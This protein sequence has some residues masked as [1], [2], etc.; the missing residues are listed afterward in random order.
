MKKIFFKLT[1]LLF[2]LGMSVNA[3]WATN[4]SGM[5]D[6]DALTQAFWARMTA[7]PA[8]TTLGSGLVFVSEDEH[9]VVPADE[10]YASTYSAEGWSDIYLDASLAILSATV[11]FKVYAKANA[12][13]YFTGWSFTDG[14]T[15]L[16]VGSGTYAAIK[17]KPSRKKSKANILD[18]TVYAAFEQVKL[19]SYEVS[20]DNTMDPSNPTCTQTVTFRAETPGFSALNSADDAKHFKLPVITN[21]AGTAGTWAT[22]ITEWNTSNISFYGDYAEIRVPVTF[23]APNGNE[24]EYGAEL[25]LETQAG[26]SMKVYLSA[27]TTGGEGQAVRYDKNGNEMGRGNLTDMIAASAATDVVKLN[28]DYA[29][30]VEINKNLTFNLNG[31]T[32]SNTLTVSGGNV[33][34]AYSAF[35]GTAD[36]LNVTGGKAIL[37]GGTFGTLTIGANATV[38]QNGA[39]ITGAATNNGT[40]T[41]TDGVFQ[42]GLTSTK[43]LTVNGGTFNGAT[44]INVTGGT[45][46]IKRGTISGTQY[47]VLTTNG[48]SATIEKLAVI[49][50]GTKALNNV[51]GTLTVNNGK[52]ADPSKFANGEITFKSAYFKTDAAAIASTYEKQQWRNTAGPEFRDEYLYFVGDQDAAQ[53]SNVSVC[54]IGKTSYASLDDAL[55]YANNHLSEE[56]II[57]MENDYTLKAGYYTIPA[58]ATLIVPMSDDQETANPV[59]PRSTSGTSTPVSFRKLIFESGVNMEVAGTLEVTCTQYGAGESMGIPG[60]NYGHLILKPG[61]HMTINNGGYLRAWGFVT[62]DGTQDSDGNYLSGE[63]DVRRGG[64]VHEMFQMGDWKGGDISFT[65]A[66]EIPGMNPCWRDM[67]HLFPIYTY[68]I[69]NVESPVKYHPGASL[70]CATSV[71]V[72]GEI[73]A[74]ANDIKVVGKEGEAAMFLMDEMADAENTWVRKYYDAKKDQ[75]VYEVNSGAKLG[76]VV[77]DLGEVPAGLITS[78]KVTGTLNLVLDSR[79]FV[80]PLTNNFKIHLLSGY[81]EFTQST[82]CLPGME[83]EVDKESEVAITKNDDATIVSGALY[84]YDADQW[85]FQNNQ[86]FGYV[87]DGKFGAIVRY[88]PTWDLGTNGATKKPEVRDISS[89]AAI[90][91]AKLIVHGTFRS[92]EDCSVYTSWSKDMT[93]LGLDESGTGGASII[94]TNEDAGT[95]IFDADAPAFDGLEM[96]PSTGMPSHLGTSVLVNYDHNDYDMDPQYPITINT[97]LGSSARVYGF[98][99]CTPAKLKN[100]DGTF[101]E[102]DG[103]LAGTSYCYIDDQWTTMQVAEDPCFMKE[104][105]GGQ[106]TYYAKPAEYVAVNVTSRVDLG[107]GVYVFNGNADHTFSDKDGAGRLFILMSDCQWWEVE[108]KDNLYHCIHPDN[109][110]YYY[111]DET[112]SAWKE[113]RFTITWLNWNGTEIKSYT[114]DVSSGDTVWE[115]YSVTYGTQAEYLGSNPTR[116]PNIDYTYDFTGWAPAL[117]KV[118][119]DVTYTATYTEQPRKYAIIFTNEGGDEIE[120]HLLT[121]NEIPVCENV[122][123]R[124]GHTLQW[125]PALAA[126][127]GDQTYRATWLEEPPTEY[128]IRFVDYDGTTVLKSDTVA[129]GEMP[130]APIITDGKPSGSEEGKPKTKEFTYVF[131]HWSP[132]VEEVTQAMTY[133]AVYREV[134]R[135]YTVTFKNEDNTTLET[136]TY[137]YGETPACSKLQT[138]ANTAQYTIALRWTPQIQ[139]VMEDTTYTAV[140]DT[141]TNK[142]TVSAKCSPAGAATFT[143][144]GTFDYGTIVNN[145]ALSYDSEAYE[146]LGWA[147]LTGAAKTVTTHTAFTLTKDTTIVADFRYKGDDKVTITWKNWDGSDTIGTSEPKVNAATTYTGAT[148][149]KPATSAE[150]YTFDGWTTEAKGKGTYYKNNLTP[151]ATANATYYAHFS[152]A[153]IPSLEVSNGV[154]QLSAP[155]TYQNLIL[156]SDGVHS[157]Q[158]LGQNYLTLTGNAYFDFK[159]NTQPRK[160]YAI[161]VPWLVD[162]ATGISANGHALTLNSGVY[163]LTYDGARRA[164]QGPQKTW[165]QLSN[166]DVMQPGILYMVCVMENASSIRFA[167][168][169]GADLLTTT[170]SVSEYPEATDNDNKDASWNGVANPAL[171]HAYVNAGVTYGQVYIPE[172]DS[173]DPIVLNTTKLVV[174]QGAYVQVPADKNITV[175]QGGEFGPTSAPRRMVAENETSN[176]EV[177]FAPI[178]QN[179]ED[180]VFVQTDDSKTPD[181]YT[182]GLDLAKMGVS[183]KIAQIW[184]DRYD[185]KLCLNTMAPVNGEAD[186]PLVLSVP[187]DG[188][189]TIDI[190]RSTNEQPNE[191]YLTR[192]GEAIWNLSQNAYTMRLE[193]GTTARYG[194]RTVSKAPQVT[195]DFEPIWVDP[196]GNAIKAAKVLINNHVY[197]I[198]DGKLYTITGSLVR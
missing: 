36:E 16:G 186:Y 125:E 67:A 26:V 21:K 42:S 49:S 116:E 146:F 118:T 144:A 18:Y 69:Q 4:M 191:L 40:L 93:T 11:D 103:T 9:S 136:K 164:A 167:K 132:A 92:G 124:T 28:G 68:F 113:Q 61:S 126:V 194:L 123:T 5:T 39:T 110:T 169:A 181:V 184:I 88:S 76:S 145:V 96:D 131:D 180:R 143:G 187:Q 27:R 1:M 190:L 79:K 24:A 130:V 134:Q 34:I 171:F 51:N 162:A 13:S 58:N 55:S 50:G 62:G 84:F 176:Y 196:E 157:G 129:V 38:E 64:T 98:E 152:A 17:V 59:V 155:V 2:L 82:S 48:G 158:L 87:G 178:N 91:D 8:T 107:E 89:P 135:E 30:P 3:A 117:G 153:S 73:N 71:N 195:T 121:H 111:W 10:D 174:G 173:Y 31:Y 137:H 179:F 189:Y 90:G 105:V 66:M 70:I 192:D 22:S 159:V 127:V 100:A 160:W 102:T 141:T 177:R 139:T 14:Y 163:V 94:S 122:P 142:Y 175:T 32:L 183:A 83:V 54:R 75:Q 133:T 193:Q 119:S 109:D 72:A 101:V 168:K 120:R 45:A 106:T 29:E 188:K 95:F 147:D 81:M 19:K 154:T 41:T 161:A 114:I 57:I 74:Y 112:A 37:N 97:V 148:P 170:T 23:T 86:A 151:K 80:L 197:I 65:I 7:K 33:T 156:T 6:D 53:A 60:G 85:S 128:E 78:G 35:G 56:V 138:K 12:G 198:R 166:G 25:V 172:S 46:S 185:T 20:G 115:D 43:I 52:F 140:F 149:T 47:G 77:I 104:I 182:V 108:K 165:T 99:L 63:I 150:T 15:D 44:A